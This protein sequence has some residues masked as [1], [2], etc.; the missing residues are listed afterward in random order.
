MYFKILKSITVL[1]LNGL[2]IER[3]IVSIT[4]LLL[5]VLLLG[6]LFYAGGTRPKRAITGDRLSKRTTKYLFYITIFFIVPFTAP[7][8]L[9]LMDRFLENRSPY[10]IVLIFLGAL[11]ILLRVIRNTFF[12]PSQ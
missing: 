9:S 1:L 3:S 5:F 4:I 6:N 12:S 10:E 7:L 2:V 11:F 8:L